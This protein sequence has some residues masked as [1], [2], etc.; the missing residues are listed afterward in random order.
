MLSEISQ[1]VAY[2]TY[3]WNLINKTNTQAK[4][5]QKHGN[6]EQTDSDQRQEGRGITG[7]KGKGLVKEHV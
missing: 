6:K 2:F 3:K 1:A 5:N 7:N 4:Y